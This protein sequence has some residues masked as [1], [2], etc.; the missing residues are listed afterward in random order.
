MER[1]AAK[2]KSPVSSGIN[3]VCYTG[4][5]RPGSLREDGRADNCLSVHSRSGGTEG[6]KRFSGKAR[7]AK[8]G[9]IGGSFLAFLPLRRGASSEAIKHAQVN[10]YLEGTPR[11]TTLLLRFSLMV[12]EN[13]GGGVETTTGK[14]GEPRKWYHPFMWKEKC[15]E[16]SKR[17]WQKPRVMP[18]IGGRT[19]YRGATKK[20]TKQKKKKKKKKKQHTVIE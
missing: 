10:S 13:G 4:G 5:R 20:K 7:T 12:S 9:G 18:V 6:K 3:Q 17:V 11:G 2:K 14:E 8:R 16:E 1:S 19:G 15:R